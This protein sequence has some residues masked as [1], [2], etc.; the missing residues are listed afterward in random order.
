[1][2]ARTEIE[3]VAH[4]KEAF[5]FFLFSLSPVAFAHIYLEQ[6]AKTM[7]KCE[8]TFFAHDTHTNMRKK[9]TEKRQIRWTTSTFNKAIKI[10]LKR[11]TNTSSEQAEALLFDIRRSSLV[12]CAFISFL[13]C[14]FMD[15]V[16]SHTF[17]PSLSL[18]HSSF[19]FL[20]KIFPFSFFLLSF[21]RKVLDRVTNMCINSLDIHPNSFALFLCSSMKLRKIYNQH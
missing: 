21:W 7:G 13:C 4:R 5:S 15:F 17:S 6:R 1:M 18:R 10:G 14:L 20:A 19:Y 3:N 12:V 8:K 2:C 9:C 11:K 16:H